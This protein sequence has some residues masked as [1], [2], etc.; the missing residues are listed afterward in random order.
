MKKIEKRSE[1]HR[2]TSFYY[3]QTCNTVLT[4]KGERMGIEPVLAEKKLGKTNKDFLQ[5]K[6][7]SLIVA[8]NLK[9]KHKWIL[10]LRFAGDIS[11]RSSRRKSEI[12][13][14][15]DRGEEVSFGLNMVM[16]YLDKKNKKKET[17][18][19]I[20]HKPKPFYN[21]Y[22]KS[23][24]ENPTAPDLVKQMDGIWIYLLSG[25]TP[26]KPKAIALTRLGEYPPECIADASSKGHKN[27]FVLHFNKWIKY[28]LVGTTILGDDAEVELFEKIRR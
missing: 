18:I 5:A 10:D 13:E 14:A 15:A 24:V 27:Q 12:K 21:V 11:F 16:T 6:E 4:L 19:I 9:K 2:L 28:T 8:E 1:Y 22:L 17:Q 3:P 26:D 7:T 25:G 23:Y 20:R